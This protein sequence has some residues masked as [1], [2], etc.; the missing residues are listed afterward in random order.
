MAKTLYFNLEDD[1]QQIADKLKHE[2]TSDLVLVFPKKSYLFSDG[3]NLKMLKKQTDLLGKKVAILTMD[4]RG[5]VYAKD[6]GFELKFLPGGGPRGGGGDIHVPRP[7]HTT[8]VTTEHHVPVHV[9]TEHQASQEHHRHAVKPAPQK[10][11]RLKKPKAPIR[12]TGPVV[13][14]VEVRDTVFPDLSPT[15]EL[16]RERTARK[17]YRKKALIGAVALFLIFVVVM[18]T[19]VLP[20]ATVVV[21]AKTDPVARD[22]EVTVSAGASTLDVSKLVL[23]GRSVDTQLEATDKFTTLGK[24]E[25][26]SKSE[27]RVRVFN[28]SSTPLNLKAGTT[29]LTVGEKK[30]VFKEDQNNIKVLQPR[31]ASDPN[32]GHVAVIVA[33]EGGESLNLPAGTRVE[34][35]NQVFGSKPEFLYART[36]TEI[37]GG[38]SRFLSVITDDDLNKAKSTLSDSLLTQLRNSLEG[39]GGILAEKAFTAEVLS[40]STD[41][42][43]GTES[44][45]FEASIKVQFKG[46][47]FSQS[48]LNELLRGRITQMLP[49]NKQLQPASGDTVTYKIKASDI[50]A[51]NSVLVAHFESKAVDIIEIDDVVADLK[52]KTKEEA[53]EMLLARPEIGKVDIILSPS[54]Q[55]SIPRFG[56]KITVEQK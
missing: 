17:D 10:T 15:T 42:P 7:Q 55:N 39:E 16:L 50:P 11:V 56:S 53:S 46:I 9:H 47:S 23:P 22:V 4:E 28:F 36:E 51:G 5:Q 52:G 14:R 35:T 1:I 41:K 43:V 3:V 20:K 25:I 27:G 40:F 2:S 31:Q 44:P 33:Q 38:N 21:Y 30:Y 26:G 24:K 32:A 48:Q 29:V 19:I 45:T 37:T 54:W 13:P 6:A 34:I 18:V 12:H 8:H 49:T